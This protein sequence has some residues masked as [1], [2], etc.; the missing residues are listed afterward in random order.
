MKICAISDLHGNL[1]KIKKCDLLL[2]AGDVCPAI[3][4]HLEFQLEWLNNDF[5]KWL[6]NIP[7]KNI[8]SIFG[9]HDFI[10]QER[11]DLIPNLRWNYLNNSSVNIGGINIYGTPWSL[12]FYDWAFNAPKECGEEF[13]EN[14]YNKIPVNTDIVL[15]HGPVF[16]YGDAVKR[17]SGIINTGSRALLN[18]INNSNVRLLVEGHIHEGYGLYKNKRTIICNASI[19]D[20]YYNNVNSPIY[21]NYT[22]KT[23]KNI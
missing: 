10:A 20:E 8:V 11:D 9:N 18:Y 12:W 5:R 6:D 19:L 17:A 3:N 4:H 2:I 22:K 7:A 15:S 16:G 14:I 23:I 13:L 1:P 21:F